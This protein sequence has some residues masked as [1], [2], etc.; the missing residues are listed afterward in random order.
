MVLALPEREVAQC[1]GTSGTNCAV[2]DDAGDS[3]GLVFVAQRDI[4]AGEELLIDYG[5]D[6][7]R[8]G[9]GS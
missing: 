2:E 1:A 8:S 9:Y 4:S 6:Y 5:F 7:D 3:E